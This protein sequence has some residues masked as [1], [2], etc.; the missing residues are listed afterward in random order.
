VHSGVSWLLQTVFK[1]PRCDEND[2]VI[3][4]EIEEDDEDEDGADSD[5]SPVRSSSAQSS[6]AVVA[7]PD[8]VLS[9]LRSEGLKVLASTDKYIKYESSSGARPLYVYMYGDFIEF[10]ARSRFSYATESQVPQTLAV[11]LLKRNGAVGPH[12]WCIEKVG[13]LFVCEVMRNVANS[14]FRQT[15]LRHLSTRLIDECEKIEKEIA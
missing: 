6:A 13:E 9:E 15:S 10:T 8:D 11:R 7:F 1:C 2:Y 3:V 4:G 5:A 14:R 12:H